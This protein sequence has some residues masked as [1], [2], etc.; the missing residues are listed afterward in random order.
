[1]KTEIIND[2]KYMKTFI[3][4]KHFEAH[5]PL[6]M[7]IGDYDVFM[8]Y[9]SIANELYFNGKE[10]EEK[11]IPALVCYAVCQA[12]PFHWASIINYGIYVENSGVDVRDIAQLRNYIKGKADA[13]INELNK[14]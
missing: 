5:S 7:D 1:M 8:P 10:V 12:L 2:R 13:L 4:V 11:D 6:K 3:S 9:L 14:E